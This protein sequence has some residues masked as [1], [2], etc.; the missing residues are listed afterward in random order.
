[1]LL[2]CF[3][4]FLNRKFN[5][6]KIYFYTGVL[7]TLLTYICSLVGLVLIWDSLSEIIVV[8]FSKILEFIPFF[9]NSVS[10]LFSGEDLIDSSFFFVNLFIHLFI[11]LFLIII[12]YI[13]TFNYK[14]ASFFPKNN[15][16]F[17]IFFFLLIFF[18]IFMPVNLNTSANFLIFSKEI[19]LNLFFT[20]WIFL[21]KNKIFFF[22]FCLFL[23]IFFFYIVFNINKKEN[24]KYKLSINNF[25]L[26]CKKH[27][28][29]YNYLSIR[30]IYINKNKNKIISTINYSLCSFCNFYFSS[31]GLLKNFNIKKVKNMFL[32]LKLNKK[33]N[34]FFIKNYKI[35]Y[36]LIIYCNS[37][38]IEKNNISNLI[39]SSLF[40]KK[41]KFILKFFKIN[42]LNS[43]NLNF[44]QYFINNFE[45]IIIIN[46]HSYSCISKFKKKIFKNN[47]LKKII[48]FDTV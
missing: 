37:K 46:N 33:N 34:F 32:N 48:I 47:D 38:K 42:Y 45:K 35:N 30:I 1:M 3:K 4:I 43:L 15:N 26:I 22:I 7:I 44:L 36:L 31:Y 19:Y 14:F 41:N 24:I 6:S 12:L 11:P 17:F 9:Q 13:H 5:I 27:K 18:S 39:Y 16:L 2:H 23:F 21:L 40:Y 29:N 8:Y 20:F 28:K 25:C 10:R